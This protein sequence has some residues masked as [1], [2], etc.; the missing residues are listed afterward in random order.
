M[1]FIKFFTLNDGFLSH[2]NGIFYLHI[3]FMSVRLRFM[4]ISALLGKSIGRE[5]VQHRKYN[6]RHY[7]FHNLSFAITTATFFVI[8]AGFNRE[9]R[10]LKIFW[11]GVKP[12]MTD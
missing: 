3:L 6:Q 7:L 9:S 1:L 11:I 8:P 4:D 5:K 10:F 2:G 12:G